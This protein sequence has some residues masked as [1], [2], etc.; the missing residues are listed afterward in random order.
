MGVIYGKSVRC[1]SA[2]FGTLLCFSIV[3]MQILAISILLKDLLG[4]NYLKALI[5]SMLL[6]VLYS[7][8]GGLHIIIITDIFQLIIIAIAI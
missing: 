6:M 8:L 7:A 2:L 1:I 4:T 3:A 5:C